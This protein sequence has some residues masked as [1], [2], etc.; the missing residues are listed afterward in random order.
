MNSMIV[1]AT[2]F[3]GRLDT[4]I[5]L[6]H[7]G[8]LGETKK[9]KY[10]IVQERT[11]RYRFFLHQHPYVQQLMQRLL[12]KGTPGLQA[13][14]TDY[15]KKADGSFETLPDGKFK[16]VL[17]ADFFKTAYNPSALVQTPYP[18]KDLDFSS[19][20]AYAVYNW[21]L[22]YHV[23]LTIAMHL[24]KNG[25]YAEAQRWFHYLFDPT[26]DSDGPTPERFWKVRPFQTTDVKKIEE[27]LV[28]LVT[29][30]DADLR[31]QTLRSI[32]AWKDAPFRP[33]VIARYRQQAY[34]YKTVMAYLDNL[35]AWGDSLFRQ[36][37]GEAIDE[38]LQI[39]VLAAN[40]LG[41]RPQA[42]PKKGSVRPQTYANL[43]KDLQ[44]FGVVLREVEAD[45]PF[46]LLP[47]PD[48]E[49]K[50]DARLATV[51]SIGRALYFCVPRNDKLLTYWDTV[52]DR[53]FKIRNSLN[54]Q[55]VFR[56]LALFEPPIDPAM[57]ARAAAAGL[58]VGAI[59]N[60]LNQPLP[61]V[62]FAFLVQKAAEIAQEV[63]S[64]GNQLL[65]AMEKEDGEA[66]A[67]LRAKHE[68]VVTQMVEQVKYAQLQEAIKAREG[69]LQ[70]LALAVQRY[71]YYERQLGKKPD[72][73]AKA[74]PQLNELDKDSLA[75]MKFAMQ[76][77][78]LLPREIE[79]DIATDFFAEAAQ[80]LSG[81]K[82]LSSYE[83]GETIL[84]EAAQVLIDHGNI[85]NVASSIAAVVPQFEVSAKPWGVGGSTTFGGQ[86]IAS[87]ISALGNTARGVADRLNFEARRANRIDSFARRERDWA[88]QSN[89]AAGE[90]NQIFKQLRA[91]QI[92]EA[93]AEQELKS[94]RRQIQHAQEIERF[95]NEEGTEKTGKKTNKALYAWM[96]REVRGL[97]AQC[98][99]FAFDIARKAE[100]ALQHE[101]GNPELSFLQFGYL[102]GKE[103]LLAGE[104]LYLDLKRMEMTYHEQNRR[105][106]ELTKHV[107][108]LQ[109]DPLALIQLRT[110]GRC[111]VRLPEAL[112]DMDG[113][114]H[115]FRRIKSV[116]LS[117]PCV[118]GPYASVNCK[119][120]LLKSSIRKTPILRDGAYAREGTE[121]DRFSDYFGSLQ[122][123]VTSSA[124]NDSGLFETNL[125][126]ERY[127]PFENSGVI[128]E[129]Q[130]ELPANPSKGEPAQFDYDTIS[131]VILHLRYT[132]R[133]GGGLLRNAAM[134][135][136]DE[137]IKAG[138][139]AGATRLF[140]VRHEFP[141]EWHRFKTQTP[142]D[143]Q[144][145]ELALTLRPE[146]YPFWA[147]GRLAQGSVTRVDL[148][149][150]SEQAPVPG[151]MD[152]FNKISDQP[153]AAEK[154]TLAKDAALGN[155]LIGIL[156]KIPLPDKPTGEFKL[157]FDDARLSDL[158]IA[159]SWK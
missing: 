64:L 24:S 80:A 40:I 72:E 6:F 139:A 20:D 8:R 21:E 13:A 135:E 116:A 126:D 41:P 118:T 86:N 35:I 75:K 120:T 50:D 93:I 57:L 133:E 101:L 9:T 11:L 103:G 83:V 62:R 122:S 61:L 78:E 73:I 137:L 46:D 98:F 147:Q 66:M 88:F 12:R 111:T 82:L 39:Y 43:Q 48:T 54:I 85:Q 87:A 99:Q 27:I 7:P 26:D 69:L 23:P 112:F 158:W 63:K 90:I 144:R 109:V 51:R 28:N 81:G 30:A 100:R 32:E 154:D 60:G 58:D 115:Y 146:H 19:G 14:D 129:W 102:A 4:D 152:V 110:T 138:Q 89:L 157:Y 77:P 71:T 145:R 53:L 34:M 17:Y 56:Q 84:M 10:F 92:R 128:S 142:P 52:A 22:F 67:I 74:I 125:R 106:Y 3:H 159:V 114:G 94:H 149:A 151:S 79:V 55:G 119:L 141:G 117:I 153:N 150:R 31:N 38:A 65:S 155:L 76:E 36:D 33:H 140:S 121:D 42:V 127:L 108:L 95:L 104:R 136:L 44:Q 124:Q 5:A 45:I 97:Y 96:K 113:P 47:Y 16:P 68:R 131:D 1:K 18:V 49:A 70:S 15:V 148:L 105:E 37:T 130:L 91:A 107:S 123:I 25:R 29:G 59:V 134:K 156:D 2:K 143:G 132:A